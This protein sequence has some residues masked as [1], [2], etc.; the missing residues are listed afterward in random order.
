MKSP[1]T[2]T[3]YYSNISNARK[4]E[5]PRQSVS[6]Q[7]RRPTGCKGVEGMQGSGRDARKWKGC[8]GVEGM[9]GSGRD[10]REWKGCEGMEGM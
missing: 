7:H 5:F 4:F 8:K 1:S 3:I 6:Q 9:Q 10:V 2:D